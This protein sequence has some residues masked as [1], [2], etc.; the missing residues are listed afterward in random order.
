M[1][2]HSLKQ[3]DLVSVFGTRSI[4]SE[5]LSGERK[6]NKEHIERLRE[7]FHVSPGVFFQ[8]RS[9]APTLL[10][11][12]NGFLPQKERRIARCGSRPQCVRRTVNQVVKR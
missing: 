4:L 8:T 12:R 1:D 10:A 6:L 11:G 9:R 2:Q 7:R 3:K 5:A